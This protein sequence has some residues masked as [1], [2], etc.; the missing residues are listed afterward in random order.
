MTNPLDS[1]DKAVAGLKTVP[2]THNTTKIT[3]LP[4][5]FEPDEEDMAEKIASLIP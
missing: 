4:D 1:F 5:E 3:E 2:L